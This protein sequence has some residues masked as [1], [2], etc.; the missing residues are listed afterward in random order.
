M[1]RLAAAGGMSTP[2]LSSLRRCERLLGRLPDAGTAVP[3]HGTTL[4]Q[5]SLERRSSAERRLR[6]GLQR[7]MAQD[8]HAAQEQSRSVACRRG[9]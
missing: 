5:R 3:P 9:A 4:S 8:A 7:S 2:R 1:L 6:W